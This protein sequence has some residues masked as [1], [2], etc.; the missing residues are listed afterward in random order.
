[1][2]PLDSFTA[3]KEG[4][5]ATSSAICGARE[6]EKS[7]HEALRGEMA[8]EGEVARARDVHAHRGIEFGGAGGGDDFGQHTEF[9]GARGDAGFVVERVPGLARH[10]QAAADEA[11]RVVRGAGELFV[12][13]AAR[14]AEIAD[15]RRG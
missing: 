12:E 9:P 15:E 3:C 11:E 14:E 7:R 8:I 13:C 6:P 10:E 4:N 2:S 5:S 1:M